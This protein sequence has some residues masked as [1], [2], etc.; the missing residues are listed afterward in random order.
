MQTWS[1]HVCPPRPQV[2][3]RLYVATVL[4]LSG[5]ERSIV[6]KARSV[7]AGWV[8]LLPVM[9]NLFQPGSIACNPE[10]LC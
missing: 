10:L 8:L 6:L 4:L 2:Q 7:K 1:W 3:Q 5:H 9:T